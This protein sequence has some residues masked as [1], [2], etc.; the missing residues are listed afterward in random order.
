MLSGGELPAML[1][2]DA[3]T[4]LIPGALGNEVSHCHESFE[5]GLLEHPHYTKPRE[6]RGLEVPQVLLEGHH[7][8]IHQWRCREALSKTAKNRPDLLKSTK[9]RADECEII[10]NEAQKS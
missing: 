7:E 6:F 8:K 4:R 3:V 9:N 2:I 10:D 1:L 5:E